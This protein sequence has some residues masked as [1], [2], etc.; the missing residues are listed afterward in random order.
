METGSRRI[1]EGITATVQIRCGRGLRVSGDQYLIIASVSVAVSGELRGATNVP[2]GAKPDILDTINERKLVG[3]TP[4][5]TPG[6]YSKGFMSRVKRDG[7]VLQK[8][9]KPAKV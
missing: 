9:T 8:A 5:S 7:F 6:R 4:R 3:V 1:A 2:K